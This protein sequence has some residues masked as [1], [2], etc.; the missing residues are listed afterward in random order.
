VRAAALGFRA[1]EG[2]SALDIVERVEGN[3]T[4]DFGATDAILAGDGDP[5]G[6]GELRRMETI[7]RACWDALDEA[8]RKAEGKALRK[9]PRGGGRDLGGIIDHVAAAE[10]G[11]LRSLGWKIEGGENGDSNR[12][13]R[14]REGVLEGLGAA[15]EGQIAA[16]GPRGGKRWLPRRFVRRLAWHALDHVWEIEERIM[17][18]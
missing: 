5:I 2:R 18:G 4:T 3:S 8:A 10:V 9:G 17:E 11:Y 16:L 15:V 12:L 13:A 6:E 1:P 14:I 7:L